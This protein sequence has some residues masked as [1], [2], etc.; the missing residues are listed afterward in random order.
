MWDSLQTVCRLTRLTITTYVL[1]RMKENRQTRVGAIGTT[2]TPNTAKCGLGS[3]LPEILDTHFHENK[4]FA[5]NFRR[6]IPTNYAMNH[7]H[8]TSIS[9][10]HHC[11]KWLYC[12]L[13]PD[14]QHPLSS[15]SISTFHYKNNLFTTL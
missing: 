8:N 2:D 4:S 7:M 9:W 3:L 11:L 15:A 1:Q 10:A 14:P 12:P 13:W 5:K 6:N